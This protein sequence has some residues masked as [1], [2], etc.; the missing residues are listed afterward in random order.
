MIKQIIKK[1]FSYISIPVVLIPLNLCA[2]SNTAEVIPL[3]QAQH[4]QLILVVSDNWQTDNGLLYRFEKLDGQWQLAKDK[5]K[6]SLG[7]TGLAWGIGLHDKQLGP[8]KKEG[9]G[10]APAG[11]F[12]LGNA[13]GYLAELN[14]GLNYQ[15]MSHN[16]YCID[17]NGSAFYNQVVSK[18][19]VG[20]QGIKGS[21]EPMRRDIH[22]N[23]DDKYKKAAVIR[24]NSQNVSSA[25]SCIFMHIW[26]DIN[27]ET[28]GC[29]AM[30]EA[31]ITA[32][33]TWL[34][35]KKQP[36]YVALPKAEYLAKKLTWAL[37]DLP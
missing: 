14:T 30:S 15:Q 24:H 22:L 17:V 33:L 20:E 13:F 18:L 29:T 37:P 16:D 1:A 26:Q 31:N 27:S 28:A 36:L 10:K 4:Q 34:D 12:T 21:S 2:Q 19:D 23:G 11:I 25:G 35:V 8:I 32:L 5:I 7:R 3:Q 9:D 6:V